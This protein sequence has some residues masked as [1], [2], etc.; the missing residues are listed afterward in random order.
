M[1]TYQPTVRAKVNRRNQ[2]IKTKL[3][4]MNAQDASRLLLAQYEF[5]SIQVC[6]RPADTP[7]INRVQP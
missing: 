2:V 1:Q 7:C 6:K 4:A 3:Q 5:H